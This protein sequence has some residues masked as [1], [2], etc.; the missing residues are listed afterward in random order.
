MDFLKEC[1]ENPLFVKVCPVSKNSKKRY[2][3]L[4]LVLRFFAFLNNYQ[5][6]QHR[7]DEFLD[8]YVES[9]KD[10]FDKD[11]FKKEFEGII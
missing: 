9:V 10:N 1:T 4:E 6:F 2:D 8:D 3:D 11:T 5:N 7:V